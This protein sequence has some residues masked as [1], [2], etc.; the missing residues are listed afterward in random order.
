MTREPRRILDVEDAMFDP[1]DH[2]PFRPFWVCFADAQPWPCEG[3]RAHVL[4]TYPTEQ[5]RGIHMARYFN[6]AVMEL[7][8]QVAR[9]GDIHR[10]FLGWIRESAES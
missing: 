5:D 1:A 9:E 7:R 8:G 3:Y 6:F 2:W 10:R 4:R